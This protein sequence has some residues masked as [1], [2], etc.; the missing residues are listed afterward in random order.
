MGS[1]GFSEDSYMLIVFPR[2]RRT[3]KVIHTSR[4]VACVHHKLV[5]GYVLV[6]TSLVVPVFFRHI[7]T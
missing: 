4:A 2:V 3:S 1:V 5:I 6:E 7:V